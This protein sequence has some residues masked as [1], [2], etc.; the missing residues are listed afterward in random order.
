MDIKSE[1][2]KLNAWGVEP[3]V[4]YQGPNRILESYVKP[5]EAEKKAANKAKK[6]GQPV[7]DIL[8][9]WEFARNW[10]MTKGTAV[11]TFI[12]LHLNGEPNFEDVEKVE[13]FLTSLDDEQYEEFTKK[14]D[15]IKNQVMTFLDKHSH[16]EYV[17]NEFWIC[18]P[19]HGIRGIVDS[20][21]YDDKK[22]EFII[23]DW[24]TNKRM[25]TKPFF[26]EKFLGSLD[27][28]YKTDVSKYGI[29]TN[30]YRD[31]IERRSDIKVKQCKLVWFNE[32]N[33]TYRT[34]RLPKHQKEIDIILQERLKND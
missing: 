13:N 14:L 6:T 21:V 12:D 25:S 33:K 27:Y 10:G 4:S 9:E 29:I 32:N 15:V 28:L 18:D 26:F 20:L 31:I 1:L 24:K 23:I 3:Q 11:H 22:D 30:L 34:I 5:F 7:E 17:A 8:R 2:I 16:Y 19:E